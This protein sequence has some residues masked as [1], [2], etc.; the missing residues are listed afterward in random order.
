MDPGTSEEDD[1]WQPP[2][3]AVL[4]ALVA[5]AAVALLLVFGFQFL[6]GNV[7]DLTGPWPT[8]TSVSMVVAPVVSEFRRCA[9]ATVP[10]PPNCPQHAAFAAATKVSWQLLTDPSR[11]AS[12]TYIGRDLYVVENHFAMLLAYADASHQTRHQFVA[13]TYLALVNWDGQAM[14][15]GALEGPGILVPPLAR[16]SLATDQS[17]FQAVAA[18]IDGCTGRQALNGA[19]LCPS[20][21]AG[22]NPGTRW[23]A[24]PAQAQVTYN[25]GDAVFRVQGPFQAILT[26]THS[27]ASPIPNNYVSGRY[28]AF[29]IWSG[30]R[31]HVALIDYAPSAA[32]P[33]SAWLLIPLVLIYFLPTMVAAKRRAVHAGTAVTLNLWFGWTVVGWL[34]ALLVALGDGYRLQTDSGGVGRVR[35]W[36]INVVRHLWFRLRYGFSE[37]DIPLLLSLDDLSGVDEVQRWTIIRGLCA[38]LGSRINRLDGEPKPIDELPVQIQRVD[39]ATKQRLHLSAEG[40]QL[41]RNRYQGQSL[42]TERVSSG[43][44]E[45]LTRLP[46]RLDG[47]GICH[48]QQ[49][50]PASQAL[51]QAAEVAERQSVYEALG[52]AI[53]ETPS[54]PYDPDLP[55]AADPVES[56]PVNSPEPATA[57]EGGQVTEVSWARHHGLAHMFRERLAIALQSGWY[58]LRYGFFLANVPQLL[59]EDD[60]APISVR[61]RE[62]YLLGMNRWLGET[63]TALSELV[64]PDQMRV[65]VLPVEHHGRRKLRFH[66]AEPAVRAL[67]ARF[68]VTIES[69]DRS[70]REEQDDALAF[71]YVSAKRPPAMIK[72]ACA[73]Y[74]LTDL[75]QKARARELAQEDALRV[76]VFGVLGIRCDAD[77][78]LLGNTE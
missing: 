72:D 65:R 48:W 33:W 25:E 36:V 42:L 70:Q 35:T 68:G 22:S 55:A 32:S 6:I 18:A 74:P 66:L 57:I 4:R 19:P 8:G 15:L 12:I 62:R 58:R 29:V 59:G 75:D 7:H 23:A 71:A 34:V 26:P 14:R 31:P 5:N 27:V 16:P 53:G 51:Q 52:V 39:G 67:A 69:I 9:A 11:G 54:S 2:R 43:A 77:A 21:P 28:D 24:S 20:M 78:T 13:S 40:V 56:G 1:V 46:S 45:Y 10:S 76:A 38:T 3:H 41:L 17:V 44:V 61:R 73:C 64:N 37:S 60:L 47:Y 49:S 50:G 63:R 30:D